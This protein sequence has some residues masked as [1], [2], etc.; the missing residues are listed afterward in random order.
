MAGALEGVRV[1]DFTMM[2][3]GP[4]AA[5]MLVDQDAEYRAV[6]DYRQYDASTRWTWGS[7]QIASIRIRGSLRGA[8]P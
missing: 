4:V 3:A 7:G 6:H 1:L 5:M 8:I 2:M